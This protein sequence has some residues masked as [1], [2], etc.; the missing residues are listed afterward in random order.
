MTDLNQQT[1]AA[2]SEARQAT[3]AIS[4]ALD[5]YSDNVLFGNLWERPDLSKRDRNSTASAQSPR[6]GRAHEAED[7]LVYRSQLCRDRAQK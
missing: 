5:S 1:N 3:Q 4:P 6:S 2:A 7:G